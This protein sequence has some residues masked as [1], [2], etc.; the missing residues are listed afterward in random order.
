MS[1]LPVVSGKKVLKALMDIGYYVRD[2]EGS[3]IH[4]RH[5]DRLPLTV[6]NHK[7]IAR[8]TLRVIIKN[9]GLSVAEFSRLLRE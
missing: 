5:P 3:H 2:Q 4:L 6:P 8:G 9:A 7:E 1:K